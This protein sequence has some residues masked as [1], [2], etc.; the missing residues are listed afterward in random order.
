MHLE[1]IRDWETPL[2]TFNKG[3]YN[4]PYVWAK[5]LG[6]TEEEFYEYLIDGDFSSW[7][8]YKIESST[9]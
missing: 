8:K 3:H 5:H 4:K 9:E 2:M 7:F 6:L 1:L